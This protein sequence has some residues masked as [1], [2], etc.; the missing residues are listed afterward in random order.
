MNTSQFILVSFIGYEKPNPI[1]AV[2]EKEE[3][4]FL[5]NFTKRL[6]ALSAS[7]KNDDYKNDIIKEHDTNG[8]SSYVRSSLSR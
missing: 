1:P 6:S 3:T 4:P 2:V 7:K 8:T 5:S